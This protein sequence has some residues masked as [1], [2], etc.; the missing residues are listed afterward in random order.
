MQATSNPN[1]ALSIRKK[2]TV[3]IIHKE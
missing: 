2:T 1:F 3:K